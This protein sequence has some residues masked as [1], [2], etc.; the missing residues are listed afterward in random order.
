MKKV[1]ESITRLLQADKGQALTEFT[2]VIPVVLLFFFGILQY[3]EVV[4]ASQLANYAAY[5]AARVYAVRAAVDGDDA[6]KEM[7]TK[8]AAMAMAPVAK[9][10][11]GE[12][13]G[14]GG[15]FAQALPADFP[16]LLGGVAKLG[17]GYLVASALRLNTQVGGG[18]VKI[19]TSGNPKQVDVE[20][21]Y[22]QPV[23]VPGL[24]ELW[25]IVAPSKG[26][27][28][29]HKSAREGLEGIPGT[30]LPGIEL[31]ENDF[32]AQFGI[33]APALPFIMYPYI[34]VRGKCAIGFSDW[35]SK[36][37]DYRPRK[38]ANGDEPDPNTDPEA[39]DLVN[40]AQGSIT[41]AQDY[42]EALEDFQEKCDDLCSAKNDVRLAEA[43]VA[44]LDADPNATTQQKE[45]AQDA[46]DVARAKEQIAQTNFDRADARLDTAER[47]LEQSTG[48]AQEDMECRCP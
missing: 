19:T 2:I 40:D 48:Q 3:F 43:E 47:A 26:L 18:S 30:V 25:K 23:Y 38:P 33:N 35:G 22:P 32:L 10:V 16:G 36:D 12:V 17:E 8:A 9:L 4:K 24:A 44:R 46:L 27:Y 37:P 5:V 21:N 7:A 1:K 14:F 41:A 20:V 34:N 13:A 28:E 15:S 31:T 45:A 42:N 11:P 39:A 6:A 29:S